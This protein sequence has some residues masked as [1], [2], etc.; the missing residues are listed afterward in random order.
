MIF[1]IHI[2]QVMMIC[3]MQELL[4]LIWVIFLEWT[5]EWKA[6]ALNNS[7]YL[8]DILTIFGIQLCQF[9]TMCPMQEWLLTPCYAF[10]LSPLN[11][12]HRGKLV[13]SI[14]VNIPYLLASTL[15]IISSNIYTSWLFVAA[16]HL[17]WGWGFAIPSDGFFFFFSK[18][19]QRSRLNIFVF[20]QGKL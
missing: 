13:S 15:S 1:G 16:Y 12:L 6:C 11:E 10:G 9:M 20:P 17:L 7:Y 18:V 2:Y 5:S 3:H 8:G 4:L 19:G 14:I